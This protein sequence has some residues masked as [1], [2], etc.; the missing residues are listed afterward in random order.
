[1]NGAYPKVEYPD[2][3]LVGDASRPFRWNSAAARRAR[4]RLG[5][6]RRE[7]LVIIHANDNFR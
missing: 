5:D 6:R 2:L 4:Q 1:M 3:R 7:A